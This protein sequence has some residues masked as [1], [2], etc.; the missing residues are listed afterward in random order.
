MG[1]S[2]GLNEFSVSMD[3]DETVVHLY[4]DHPALS[5]NWRLYSFRPSPD[6]ICAVA[7][8]NPCRHVLRFHE[9]KH[10]LHGVYPFPQ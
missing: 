5:G 1:I 6:Y 4:S 2:F 10:E 8:N 3:P 7:V 9:A